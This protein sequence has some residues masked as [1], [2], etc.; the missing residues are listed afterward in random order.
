MSYDAREN[1][2]MMARHLEKVRNSPRCSKN[3][4]IVYTYNDG[5]EEPGYFNPGVMNIGDYVQS[6]AARQFFSGI[7]EYVDRDLLGEYRGP[8][9][10]MSM[11]AWYSIWRKNRVFAEQINPLMVAVH[12]NNGET[13][14]DETFAYFRRHQPIGCRDLSTM[15][16]LKAHG[17]E[18]YFSGCLTLT[19]GATYRVE[20]SEREDVV[21][22]VDYKLGRCPPI[23][24]V[25]LKILPNYR[26]CRWESLTKWYALSKDIR[27]CLQE[28]EDVVKTFARARLVITTNIHS[29]LPC[30][31]LGTPVILACP[32]YDYKRF[33]GI[34]DFFNLVGFGADGE[35][36]NR[37]CVDEVGEVQNP[38]AHLPYQRFLMEVGSAFGDD[39]SRAFRGLNGSRFSDHQCPRT[40]GTW[41]RRCRLIKARILS[42]APQ[43][44]FNC[45]RR[46]R[47]IRARIVSHAPQWVLKCVRR[48]RLIKAKIL[49][50]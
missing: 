11:N 1:A 47:R 10:N 6:L 27:G 20:E 50:R 19:L 18:A 12:I 5:I 4:L 30:L 37:I 39:K 23:N 28:A 35:E 13:L 3:G 16:T 41:L 25:L 7:D 2:E 38:V 22:F 17:V 34:S 45:M 26:H 42:C 33:E 8:A 9:V 15:Q 36:I 48:F 40:I 21:L 43:L 32:E 24:K 46:Y 29:A 44:A 31:A 49:S 14:E